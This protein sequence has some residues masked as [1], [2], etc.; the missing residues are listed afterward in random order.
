MGYKVNAQEMIVSI[1]YCCCY[2]YCC[3]SKRRKSLFLFQFPSGFWKELLVQEMV[4]FSWRNLYTSEEYSSYHILFSSLT[5]TYLTFGPSLLC[6]VCFLYLKTAAVALILMWEHDRC[7]LHFWWIQFH[8]DRCPCVYAYMYRLLQ[9]EIFSK[10][11]HKFPRLDK[12][13]FLD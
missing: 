11:Q 3:W 6:H 8:V 10:I 12:K 4:P 13:S 7:S 5:L 9:G 2:Y 1:N